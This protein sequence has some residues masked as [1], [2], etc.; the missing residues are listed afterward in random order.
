MRDQKCPLCGHMAQFQFMPYGKDPKR[1]TCPTCHLF[2]IS[3]V[4]EKL[5]VESPEKYRL[6]FSMAS[7]NAERGQ[8]L[9]I[10]HKDK[11]NTKEI[12]WQYEPEENWT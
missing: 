2:V 8:I 7:K 3:Q 12:M 9:H 5:V 11:E 10:I 6:S 1:F 4:T